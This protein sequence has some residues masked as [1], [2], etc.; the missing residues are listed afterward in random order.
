[1]W[2]R[3]IHDTFN[4]YS[5]Q[6]LWGRNKYLLNPNYF[7]GFSTVTSW[8]FGEVFLYIHQWF[9]DQY[10]WGRI[11]TVM[12]RSTTCP[13]FFSTGTMSWADAPRVLFALYMGIFTGQI[14]GLEDPG[15]QPCTGVDT[16]VGGGLRG[17]E[18][19]PRSWEG[20]SRRSGP[21]TGNL[22]TYFYTLRRNPLL[23]KLFSELSLRG[24]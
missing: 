6:F 15:S 14:W 3:A 5:E 23:F 19:Q 22:E 7:L 1:M 21:T 16:A 8:Y 24:S 4:I 9:L 13:V 11:R 10:P 2:I 12:T 20:G 18:K 17:A